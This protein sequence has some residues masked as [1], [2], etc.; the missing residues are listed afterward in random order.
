MTTTF[1][2]GYWT[3]LKEEAESLIAENGGAYKWADAAARIGAEAAFMLVLPP[4]VKGV[5]AGLARGA[6]VVPGVAQV[7]A[8]LAQVGKGV[9]AMPYLGR[10]VMVSFKLAEIGAAG[11]QGKQM[12]DNLMEGI[13][14]WQNGD[15]EGAVGAFGAADVDGIGLL[16][17]LQEMAKEYG[18]IGK[19][20]AP[21]PEAPKT[22]AEIEAEGYGLAAERGPNSVP[23]ASERT[24]LP[25]APTE[26]GSTQAGAGTRGVPV[27]QE[28]VG[29]YV[30]KGGT[31]L[32]FTHKTTDVMIGGAGTPKVSIVTVDLA[33]PTYN[34]VIPAGRKNPLTSVLENKAWRSSVDPKAGPGPRIVH[35]E[36]YGPEPTAVQ[37]AAIEAAI[38]EA[39]RMNP[40][41][42][43]IWR[44]RP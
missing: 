24:P 44:H 35:A 9:L 15:T 41:V 20:N 2:L 25:S 7:G 3:P 4:A 40:P 13:Q 43:I 27:H 21:A 22:P 17:T 33:S 31:D 8:K 34:K 12:Y 6:A 23:P 29:E 32:G 28:V 37:Q 39:A 30:N 14:R 42:Q 18:G 5:G 11:L 38:T 36:L 19:T 16:N 10:T 26:S 1:S